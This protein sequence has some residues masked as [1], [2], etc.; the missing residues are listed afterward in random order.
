MAAIK[1]MHIAIHKAASSS[2]DH[3]NVKTFIEGL[4]VH[5]V[6][7][8]LGCSYSISCAAHPEHPMIC[9]GSFIIVD[10]GATYLVAVLCLSVEANQAAVIICVDKNGTEW[11]V[12]IC[13]AKPAVKWGNFTRA[14]QRKVSNDSAIMQHIYHR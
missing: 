10:G 9:P 14:E 13:R 11:K 1:R 3:Q 8:Y 2:P 12:D 4:P 6:F 5:V 7:R